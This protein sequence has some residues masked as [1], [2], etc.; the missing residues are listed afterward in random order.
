LTL[1]YEGGGNVVGF[2]DKMARAKF[3]AIPDGAGGFHDINERPI[4]MTVHNNVMTKL[5]MYVIDHHGN[6]LTSVSPSSRQRGG[7]RGV[8]YFN[9]SSF[10]AGREVMCAGMI[11]IAGGKLLHIDNQ[12]GHYA[13]T[14]QHLTD[15]LAFLSE[16]GIDLS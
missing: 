15:A 12:S 7:N 2:F 1:G 8:E 5:H 16:E 10:N 3:L 11:W 6:L 14:T 4:N 9:H 13:P